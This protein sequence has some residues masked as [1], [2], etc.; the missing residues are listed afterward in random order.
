MEQKIGERQ[1]WV[2]LASGLSCVAAAVLSGLEWVW[3]LAAGLG[4][5]FYYY[6]IEKR[7]QTDGV[8]GRLSESFGFVG[9]VLAVLGLF[10]CVLVMGWCALL[11]DAAFPLVDGFPGLGW[12]LLALTAWGSRRGPRAC[13]GCAGILFLFLLGLY[14]AIA[15][16]SVPDVE[17]RYLVPTPDWRQGLLAAGM[18]LLPS[19]VWYVP[20]R[21]RKG[22][23]QPMIFLLPLFAAALS[24][25]TAGVLSP[26]VAKDTAVPVYELAR[27]VSVLGVVERIEP[28][29]SAAIIMGLFCLLA[30]LAG[31]C[32]ALSDQVEPWQ[33]SGSLCC[34]AA[35]GAMYLAKD[36]PVPVLCAGNGVFFFVIPLAAVTVSKKSEKRC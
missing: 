32:Q 26:E 18:F 11:A 21:E 29:L 8:A 2:W 5:C 23:R 35:A 16:F 33:W 34:L 4:I 14:G 36:L 31:A 25:V 28:L 7:L 13:A 9:K 12:V 3:V 22:K 19:G 27:S 24:A 30:G 17:W 20:V 15:V 1:R 10:W 6:Y